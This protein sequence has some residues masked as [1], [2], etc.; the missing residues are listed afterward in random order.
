[1]N[2]YGNYGYYYGQTYSQ[3]TIILV[4]I[5]IPSFSSTTISTTVSQTNSKVSTQLLAQQ[6]YAYS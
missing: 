3:P 4:Q 2:P 1:M 5:P 6:A